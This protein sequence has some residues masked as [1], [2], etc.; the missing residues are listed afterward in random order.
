MGL[1]DLQ[2]KIF[3]IFGY[4][5]PIHWESYQSKVMYSI[6]S[7][8]MTYV[9]YVYM[10]AGVLDVVFNAKNLDD[11]TANC[12]M[13]LTIVSCCC[14][15]G[16]MLYKYNDIRQLGD[17]LSHKNCLVADEIEQEIQDKLDREARLFNIPRIHNY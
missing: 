15:G 9:M 11:F 2:F 12:Y 17:M 10:L 14:K 1:L 6:Y 3:T 8:F 4:W 13:M 5:R 16:F 7:A